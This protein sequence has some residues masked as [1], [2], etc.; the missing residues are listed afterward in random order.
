MG[1]LG[2]GVVADD[3]DRTR[4]EIALHH[5]HLRA[6]VGELMA[7]ELAFVRGVDGHLNRAQLQRGE[8]G[9]DLL[10]AVV[11]EGGD[12]IAMEHAELSQGVREVVRFAVHLACGE[13]HTVAGA[14]GEVEVRT[15]R[16]R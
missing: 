4:R 12:A 10:G 13:L 11:E 6:R 2:R 7:E 5:E 14:A 9:D 16:I 15:V 1:Q 8:E 3:L